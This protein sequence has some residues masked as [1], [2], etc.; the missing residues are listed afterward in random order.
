MKYADHFTP[1]ATNY[2]EVRNGLQQS[3]LSY[4]RDLHRDTKYFREIRNADWDGAYLH[5]LLD[6]QHVIRYGFSLD[7][8]RW[9]GG[10]QLGIGPEYFSPAYFWSYEDSERF[11]DGLDAASVFHNLRLLDEFL[12]RDGSRPL[13]A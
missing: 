7:Q 10:L 2:L 5:F 13:I 1:Q 12:A 4:Y 6:R 9:V 3:V 11:A 8:G